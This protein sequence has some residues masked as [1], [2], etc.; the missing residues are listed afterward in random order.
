MPTPAPR[1]SASDSHRARRLAE[2]FGSDAERYDRTRPGYPQA[3]VERIV[4]ASPGLDV[5][6]VGIGTG[7]SARPFRAAGCRVLGVEVDARMAELARRRGFEVEVARFE[8]WEPAGRMFDLVVAGQA[9][10]WVDPVAGARRAAEL[11]G[12]GGRLAVFW[13]A[14]ELPPALAAAF[15]AVY[16]RVLPGSPFSG[17]GPGGA[18]G[19]AAFYAN[20][21]DGMRQAGGFGAAEQWQV[22]WQRPYTRDEWL[23]QVPTFGGHSQFPAEQLDELLAG[24]GAAIDAVGGSFTVS[25]AAV[26]VTAARAGGR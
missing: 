9:W 20:A 26:A 16:Q 21:A 24:I 18:R 22:N 8:E 19:Y 23:D 11:L 3:L 5:L 6:D 15:G 2:G 17:G 12:P 13:N 10:H 7:T 14:F 4:A 1:F 25:Y